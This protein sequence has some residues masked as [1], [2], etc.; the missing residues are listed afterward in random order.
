MCAI[1]GA[2]TIRGALPWSTCG[3]AGVTVPIVAVFGG[4]VGA[5][6]TTNADDDVGL[7]IGVF[8]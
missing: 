4:V 5:A 1:S 3:I 7:A 2:A 8:T 6:I